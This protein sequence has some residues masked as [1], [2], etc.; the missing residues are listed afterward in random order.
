MLTR[1]MRLVPATLVMARAE[2]AD[3]SCFATL[4]SASIPEN[5]PPETLA[6]ALPIFLQLLEAAPDQVGWLIW[7]ALLHGTE[8]APD[9][10]VGSVGFR[11]PPVQGT[12]EIGYSVL[13]QYQGC[14]YATEM[15]Q[16]L[17]DW[18]LQQPGVDKVIAEAD[19]NNAASVRVLQKMGFT[20]V[21]DAAEPGHIR[22]ALS[23]NAGQ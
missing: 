19:P 1:R 13:P 6:D 16:G 22:F 7:Y 2:I 12:V 3:R 4:L 14:G 11:G 8:N 10:L 17:T 15:V 23:R 5:W 20:S 18:A 21:G 9:I